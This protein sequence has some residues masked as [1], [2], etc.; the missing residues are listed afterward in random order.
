MTVK[1]LVKNSRRG[2]E[3]R[4]RKSRKKLSMATDEGGLWNVIKGHQSNKSKGR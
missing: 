4:R 2:Q 3:R 1:C